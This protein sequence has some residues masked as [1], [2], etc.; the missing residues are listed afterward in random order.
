[1]KK[2]KYGAFSVSVFW[3][4]MLICVIS[5][6][7]NAYPGQGDCIP[8]HGVTLI[9]IPIDPDAN[10]VLDGNGL[11]SFWIDHNNAGG[12]V[13]VPLATTSMEV[14]YLNAT[15]IMTDQYILILC[16]W[17]DSTII[18][19]LTGGYCD[20][21]FF[22]WNIDVPH[23][24][25]NFDG[26]NT[27]S[28]G[29]GKVDDWGWRCTKESTDTTD[30]YFDEGGWGSYEPLQNIELAWTNTTK[31][32]T[33]EIKRKLVTNDLNDVQINE[34]KSYEFNIAILNDDRH[35]NHYSSWTY[36][37]DLN[38]SEK[39]EPEEE[40]PV[41]PDYRFLILIIAFAS[42]G[43]LV[44][45]MALPSIRSK[46]KI[47]S[48]TKSKPTKDIEKEKKLKEELLKQIPNL[49]ALSKKFVFI[50]IKEVQE[51]LSSTF[52]SQV[53]PFVRKAIQNK[54]SR[55]YDMLRA[56]GQKLSSTQKEILLSILFAESEP[57]RRDLT[58]LLR[59]YEEN[60]IKTEKND[61]GEHKTEEQRYKADIEVKIDDFLKGYEEWGRFEGDMKHKE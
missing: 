29:G 10:V 50:R 33:V 5:P 26:M 44:V 1:M 28:M 61:K 42:M 59:R 58:A 16:T 53:D 6:L 45:A 9:N 52:A 3:I 39:E 7:T 41:K 23:F 11:E 27:V 24:S 18:P 20:G 12:K 60:M 14:I 48:R 8:Q 17:L 4:F 35:Q 49:S 56:L 55:F 19:D 57:I 34:Q 54:I 38:P 31:S 46:L 37:L 40:E 30:S 22:C 47:K 32:Y 43:G 13:R 21:I 2:Y 25:A 15:F 51:S 36:A